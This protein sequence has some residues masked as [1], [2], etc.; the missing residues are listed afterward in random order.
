[1]FLF[2]PQILA[3]AASWLDVS[4]VEGLGV[5][6][7]LRISAHARLLGCSLWE[8]WTLRL[9]GGEPR[10]V[11]PNQRS[12]WSPSAFH[13]TQH[14]K[15]LTEV[16]TLPFLDRRDKP[17][18]HQSGRLVFGGKNW[19]SENKK[20]EDRTMCLALWRDSNLS[21]VCVRSVIFVQLASQEWIPTEMR[22]LLF[23]RPFRQKISVLFCWKTINVGHSKR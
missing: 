11:F 12:C 1:M 19:N 4:K 23:P 17:F 16:S 5:T 18:W 21:F 10:G 20:Q 13:K 7:L 22:S 2:S 15:L 6:V 9:L 8:D 14:P 3:E